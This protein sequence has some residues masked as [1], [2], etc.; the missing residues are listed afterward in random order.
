MFRY[1]SPSISEGT[2]YIQAKHKQPPEIKKRTKSKKIN[3]NYSYTPTQKERPSITE[4]TLL[5]KWNSNG[6]FSIPMYFISFLEGYEKLS[7]GSHTYL[8]CTNATIDSKLK[9]KLTLRNHDSNDILFFC[10]DIE[11]TSYSFIFENECNTYVAALRQASLEKLGQMIVLHFRY[12]TENKSNYSSLNAY[13]D[14][15][16]MCV[17][18]LTTGTGMFKCLNQRLLTACETSIMGKLRS[19]LEREYDRLIRAKLSEDSCGSWEE[20]QFMVDKSFFESGTKDTSTSTEDE[21]FYYQKVDGVI[22]HFF[23]EFMLV[24]GSSNEKQLHNRVL[25]IMPHWIDDRATT[26]YMLFLRLFDLMKLVK[27]TSMDIP[28]L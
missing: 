14:L 20:M 3:P 26:H 4:E 7:T 8:L 16:Y 5:T 1:S 11:A 13:V 23:K 25:E 18:E 2:V 10:N 9:Q 6:R 19:V 22:Q 12:N 28:Y 24:C 21:S 15:I 17:E 27:P